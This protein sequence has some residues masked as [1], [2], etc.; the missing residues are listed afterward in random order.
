MEMNRVTPPQGHFAGQNLIGAFSVDVYPLTACAC[1]K[2]R[3]RLGGKAQRVTLTKDGQK[4]GT[5]CG[6]GYGN[7]RHRQRA[8]PGLLFTRVDGGSTVTPAASGIRPAKRPR[9]LPASSRFTHVSSKGVSRKRSCHESG[10]ASRHYR[11]G[12]PGD[13]ICS[14]DAQH[15]GKPAAG[16]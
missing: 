15:A 6:A 13:R 11:G 8:M 10:S 4:A 2:G 5:S 3:I 16:F 9:L 7:G 14:A 12:G 1:V